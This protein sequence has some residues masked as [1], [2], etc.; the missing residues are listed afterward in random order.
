M[1]FDTIG[2]MKVLAVKSIEVFGNL[3]TV[4]YTR[5]TKR[6]VKQNAHFLFATP[7]E[8]RQKLYEL[9][10]IVEYHDGVC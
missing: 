10:D 2:G 1:S 3:W 9:L 4:R 8:A 6:G 7:E 5:L